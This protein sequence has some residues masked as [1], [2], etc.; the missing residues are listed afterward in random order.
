[1]NGVVGPDATQ[2]AADVAR[3]LAEDLGDGDLTAALL[4]A[5]EWGRAQV[6]TREPAVMCGQ[7]WAAACFAT[8]DPRVKCEWLAE[9]GANLAANDVFLR[10]TGPVRALVSGERAALNFLQTLMATATVSRQFANAVS[11]TRTRILDTRKTLPGLRH[12]QKYAVRVGGASNHRIG[13]FDA[14]LIKENHIAAAGSIAAAIAK[15]RAIAGTRMVEIEVESLAELQLALAAKPDRIMLDEFSADDL[16]AAVALAQGQVELE[17]SGS[18]S[19]ERLAAVAALGVDFI[20]VGALTKH[21][22][23]IDLS[24]RLL[25]RI[26]G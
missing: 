11:G 12:A 21:V 2:V 9:E 13:L 20:S 7:A 8:I 4:P 22:R 17:V 24:M 19:L 3:A 16:Q 25:G 6:L 14:V 1:M 23:A 5:D 15:A 26:D 18:M 10:L